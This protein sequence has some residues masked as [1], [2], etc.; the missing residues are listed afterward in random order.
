MT[1]TKI[2]TLT[3]INNFYTFFGGNPLY[4]NGLYPNCISTPS[5]CGDGDIWEQYNLP[6]SRERLAQAIK[7]SE[8]KVA[9]VIGTFVRPNWVSEEIDIPLHWSNKGTI[10]LQDITFQ[11]KYSFI[12]RFG[13]KKLTKI[14]PNA[15]VEYYD[16]DGD[17]F[18]EVAELTITVPENVNIC[19]LKFYHKDTAYELGKP[20]LIVYDSETGNADYEIDSWLLVRPELYIN[21]TF[22][23]INA[24]NACD[25]ANFVTA[26]DVY[27]EAADLCKPQV[28]IL[29]EKAS[30]TANC[31]Y[32]RQ[33]ACAKMVNSC[34]GRFK[35]SPQGY[36]EDGCVT[37]SSSSFCGTASKIIVHYQAGCHST[38]CL[39]GDCDTDC[40][41][42]E[43]ETIVFKLAASELPYPTCDCSCIQSI[44][45][46]YQQQT[47][48]IVKAENRV[49]NY[50]G[51]IKDEAIFG[52]TV[53]QIEAAMELLLLAEK[54][55]KYT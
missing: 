20:R 30:C 10:P 12:K 48:L 4:F 15:S 49:F 54:F 29:Y 14:I 52:T 53:G 44:L 1:V 18:E 39:P 35:I 7:N 3:D 40:F 42:K 9:E 31:E 36:D 37:N 22:S 24:I 27:E 55:C 13:Q 38:V 28:E 46:M 5:L 19:D 43:L 45:Q 23:A 2:K 6:L 16:R 34:E 8:N 51:W 47:S 21:Q 17:G 33:P 26:I 41:C 32:D 25:S 11:S 50:P